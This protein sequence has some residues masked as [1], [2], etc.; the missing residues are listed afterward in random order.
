M[1]RRATARRILANNVPGTTQHQALT[2]NLGSYLAFVFI[3]LRSTSYEVAVR[4]LKQTVEFA[5]LQALEA[6][7]KQSALAQ[8]WEAQPLI[9]ADEQ[10]SEEIIRSQVMR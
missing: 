6:V 1:T 10:P 2:M 7:E 9:V 3:A 5:F 8:A 4:I